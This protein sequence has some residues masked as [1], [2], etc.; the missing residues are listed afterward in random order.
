MHGMDFE[1]VL[2]ALLTEFDRH[3][4]RYAAIG[5]FAL[6]VLGYA[7]ATMDLDF[8]VHRD[9]LDKLD[10]SIT[11]LGYERIMQTENVS[12]YRY[13]DESWCGVDFI[14]AFRKP[15]LA[16]L[17][18]AKSYPLFG[19]TQSIK[20]AD[21]EDVIGLK[22]QALTNDPDRKPQELADIEALMK[23]YGPRLD[24]RRVQEFYD[25]FGMG[26][27]ARRMKERFDVE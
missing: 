16:M 13:R 15:T 9:D 14:H 21:P 18:R 12:H 2:K 1:R 6:G 26:E 17:S 25:I 10:Q 20:S 24:W 7:R 23:L 4:I 19:G 22:V 5:G 27:D 8:L 11:V 3:R